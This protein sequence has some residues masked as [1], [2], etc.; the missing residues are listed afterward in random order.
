MSVDNA[1]KN[2]HRSDR[3]MSPLTLAWMAISTSRFRSRRSF[4]DA[5]G[6]GAHSERPTICLPRTEEDWVGAN[7]VSGADMVM[8]K[9]QRI[10][11]GPFI[12]V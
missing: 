8:L 1:I 9:K 12:R 5:R 6:A 11:A 3:V 10:L 7:L 4:T 2:T